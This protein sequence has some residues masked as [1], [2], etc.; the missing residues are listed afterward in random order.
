MIRQRG[1]LH[2]QPSAEA[3]ERM[4][5][6]SHEQAEMGDMIQEYKVWSLISS[7]SVPDTDP[8]LTKMFRRMENLQTL[9]ELKTDTSPNAPAYTPTH[10][11]LAPKTQQV[12]IH[13][14]RSL[15][16]VTLPIE[17]GNA[18]STTLPLCVKPLYLIQQH[19]LEG[20]R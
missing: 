6:A 17:L 4:A 20:K 16:P 1:N 8:E 5:E 18:T 11:Y 15:L 9:L 12:Q 10:V 14:A 2:T 3:V 7:L 19:F 13:S